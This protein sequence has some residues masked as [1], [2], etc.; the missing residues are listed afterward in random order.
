MTIT[1]ILFI[2]AGQPGRTPNF[3]AL[4]SVR[5]ASYGIACFLAATLVGAPLAAG[6]LAG[7]DALKATPTPDAGVQ[8]IVT[9][10]PPPAYVL[11]LERD[12]F[13]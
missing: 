1:S 2:P 11:R 5:Q 3:F 9:D 6:A 8:S 10:S 12:P 7:E 4:G 13:R